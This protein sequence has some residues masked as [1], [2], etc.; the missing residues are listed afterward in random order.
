MTGTC[1]YCTGN[2]ICIMNYINDLSRR[3]RYITKGGGGFLF[4]YYSFFRKWCCRLHKI[5]PLISLTREAFKKHYKPGKC[6]SIDEGMIRYKGQHYARQYTPC[7]PIK[8]GLKVGLSLNIYE[9]LYRIYVYVFWYCFII[10]IHFFEKICLYTK[11][12]Y[13]LSKRLKY[14]LYWFF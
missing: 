11:F 5:R 13:L 4:P 8:R 3:L 1:I 14:K 2:T 9:V 12:K 6:Q 10:I 7:K